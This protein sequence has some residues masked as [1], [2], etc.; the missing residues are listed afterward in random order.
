MKKETSKNSQLDREVSDMLR[1]AR[2]TH[3]RHLKQMPVLTDEQLEKLY[4]GWCRPQEEVPPVKEPRHRLAWQ[5][6][7]SALFCLVVAGGCVVYL[8]GSDDV[9]MRVLMAV[10]ATLGT[11]M[12]VWSLFPQLSSL[13]PLYVEECADEELA[14]A[15]MGM[16]RC[17]PIGVTLLLVLLFV[18]RQPVG[19]G[20]SIAMMDGSRME[21]V[22]DI[23]YIW[24]CAA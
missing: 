16:K 1:L 5:Q 15:D 13:F 21:A 4:F 12:A 22:D 11:L 9:P 20:Y 8:C 3:R 10:L 17:A 14:Y 6:V 2:Q 18:F 19:D 23:T 7:L 24:A